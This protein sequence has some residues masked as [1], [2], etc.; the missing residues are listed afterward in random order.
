M[1]FNVTTKHAELT[2]NNHSICF[3]SLQSFYNIEVINIY[4]KL[5]NHDT[6]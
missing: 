3:A 1:K 2:G 4:L 5:H 6:D